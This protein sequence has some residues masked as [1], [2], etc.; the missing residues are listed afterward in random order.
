ME[1]H[2]QAKEYLRRSRLEKANRM[3]DVDEICKDAGRVLQLTNLVH[4]MELIKFHAGLDSETA[5]RQFVTGLCDLLFG[6]TELEYRFIAFCDVLSDIGA[7][8][9][10]TATYFPFIMYPDKYMFMKP[11]VTIAAAEICDFELN[12]KPQLNW[13]TYKSLLTFAAELKERL[14]ELKPRDFID[15]QSFIWC[16]LR[17][18]VA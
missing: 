10:T 15:V 11:R 7:P 12:Y 13:L 6:D 3:G 16:T 1:A 14:R 2:Q 4:K 5:K 18:F 17:K 8:N 9:W